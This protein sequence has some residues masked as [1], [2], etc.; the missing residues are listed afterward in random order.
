[1]GF[2]RSRAVLNK[3]QQLIKFDLANCLKK[4]N[5]IENHITQLEE[6]GHDL[7]TNDTK[8]GNSIHYKWCC[9][10]ETSF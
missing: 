6:I 9:A 3:E 5:K 2:W 7:F 1:M 8:A 4:V 10:E